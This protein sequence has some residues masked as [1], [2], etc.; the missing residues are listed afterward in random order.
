MHEFP[1]IARADEYH[2]RLLPEI[3]REPFIMPVK[4]PLKVAI[5]TSPNMLTASSR[6]SAFRPSNR[7]NIARSPAAFAAAPSR[8][9][10]FL[11]DVNFGP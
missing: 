4:W 3:G 9:A 2:G 1:F 5:P 11:N 7:L 6:M 8:G 10:P